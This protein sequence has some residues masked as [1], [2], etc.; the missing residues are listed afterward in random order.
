MTGMVAETLRAAWM[1]SR[2][3]VM[4]VMVSMQTRSAPAPITARICARKLASSVSA[5]V[6]PKGLS[7]LPLGPHEAET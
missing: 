4:S 5:S 2:A 3:S 1:A 7:I 6:S